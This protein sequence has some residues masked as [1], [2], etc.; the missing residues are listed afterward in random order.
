MGLK[1]EMDDLG[2]AIKRGWG[3]EWMAGTISDEQ[4]RDIESEHEPLDTSAKKSGY[5]WIVARGD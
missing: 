5:A 2:K 3:K 4:R 1:D